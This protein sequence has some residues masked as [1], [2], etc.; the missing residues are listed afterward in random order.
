MK[1][2]ILLIALFYS[3]TFSQQWN[4][5]KQTT[6]Q[7]I[8]LPIK[9]DVFTNS[10][11]NHILIE[12]SN[13]NIIYYNVNSSGIVDVAK[14]ETIESNGDFPTITGS[15]DKVYIFYKIGTNIKMKYSTDGGGNW[16]YNAN[17]D[18]QINSSVCNG[19][20]AFYELGNGV[21]LVWAT[22][23]NGSDYE[24]YYYRLNT[25]VT[26]FQWVESKNVTDVSNYQY[27]G[28][29]SVAVSTNRVD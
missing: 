1:K 7:Q 27:G 5:L 17:L 24:T 26:P 21:H 6:I 2:I 8:S 29:P 19:I 22:K 25:N 3:L 20:D 11:G 10:S 23:D 28:N 14:T 13:G 15:S 4:D 12:A 9:M 16:I 18:R